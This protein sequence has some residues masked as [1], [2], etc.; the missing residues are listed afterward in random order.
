[1]AQDWN[2]E[3]YARFQDL[4]LRPALDL[5]ARVGDLP[6]GKVIDL[7]CGTGAAAEA[8]ADR[9]PERK[10]IGV[11]SSPAMIARAAA[12]GA[13]RRVDLADLRDWEPGKPPAL[14][15]SNAVLHWVGDHA[16]LLPRLAGMLAPG[17]MLAVQMPVQWGAPSHRFLRDFAADMFP[18]RF[19]FADWVPPVAAPVEYAR[20][21]APL[22]LPD[23]WTTEYVQRLPRD[24]GVHPVRR[25]TESTA[26]RPI[27]AELSQTELAAFL[28]RYEAA[29]D[30]AYPAEADGTVLFPFR[31]LFFTLRV[32]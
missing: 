19:D 22:G 8:L 11:D 15:F 17:G 27:A 14:I 13:Y 26:L 21:L 16:A 3:S 25:F 32:R 5:I 1:M 24:G 10:I 2:P 29:L 12:T 6:H 31:R 9:W 30:I 18:D 7:G 23:V 4:R 28:A 20:L